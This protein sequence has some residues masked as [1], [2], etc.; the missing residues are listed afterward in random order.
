MSL[1]QAARSAQLLRW[2]PQLAP[3]AGLRFSER[4]RWGAL[5]PESASKLEFHCERPTRTS[6]K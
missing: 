5:A 2:L 6:A 1:V 3:F 4:T